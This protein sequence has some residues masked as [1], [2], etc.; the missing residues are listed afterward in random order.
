VCFLPVPGKK[1]THRHIATSFVHTVTVD[2]AKLDKIA[3][4]L[5]ISGSRKAKL[6]PGTKIHVVCEKKKK[7][8]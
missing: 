7:R 8:G 2:K 4:A 6:T 1:G 5:G 3:S